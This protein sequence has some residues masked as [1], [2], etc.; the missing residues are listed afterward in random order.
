MSFY[1]LPDQIRFDIYKS[2]EQA[3]CQ[4]YPGGGSGLLSVAVA[5]GK[6]GELVKK[7]KAHHLRMVDSYT[8]PLGSDKPAEQFRHD[9]PKYG[10]PACNWLIAVFRV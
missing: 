1:D 8:F 5:K 6:F 2:I 3:G 7:M 4:T 10:V 9:S